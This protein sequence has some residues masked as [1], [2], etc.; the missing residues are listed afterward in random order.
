MAQNPQNALEGEGKWQRASSPSPADPGLQATR[1][2][3][4]VELDELL[5]QPLIATL[6]TYRKDGTVLLSPVWH[7]WRDEGFN[8]LVGENDIKLRHIQERPTAS[9]VVYDHVP[10]Y[11]GVE[12]RCRARV[13]EGGYKDAQRR[14]ADRYLRTVAPY[15]GQVPHGLAASGLLLRLE[16]EA[17]RSW[18]FRDLFPEL[19]GADDRHG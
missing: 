10:P 18:Q 11:R 13:I 1:Q 14:M 2:L 7:E 8:V 12:A 4:Q 5:E 19:E 17:V 15:Y 6:A 16:P 3:T 9:V